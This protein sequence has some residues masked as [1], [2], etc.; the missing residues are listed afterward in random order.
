MDLKYSK[1]QF[2]RRFFPKRYSQNNYG[3]LKTFSCIE[4][5]LPSLEVEVA[6]AIVL[7]FPVQIFS[8]SL[9]EM[10][11]NIPLL[12]SRL[13]TWHRK[14]AYLKFLMQIFYCRIWTITSYIPFSK[15]FLCNEKL[16]W[17]GVELH[18]GSD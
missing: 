11:N 3:R 9:T 17:N 13:C 2:Q 10:E 5:F 6:F 12:V 15:T 18:E 14:G 4:Q 1:S 8:C 7:C 16:P